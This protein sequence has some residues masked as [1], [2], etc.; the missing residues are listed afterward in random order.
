M[1][2]DEYEEFIRKK[3]LQN[4]QIHDEEQEILK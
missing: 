4:Q 2:L 3:Q 1:K